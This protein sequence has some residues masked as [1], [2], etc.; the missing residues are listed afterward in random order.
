M[1]P[2]RDWWVCARSQGQP[3]GALEREND[4]AGAGKL[5]GSLLL[6]ICNLLRLKGIS[7]EEALADALENLLKIY[8]IE[9]SP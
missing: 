9:D 4:S 8:E 7:G 5:A 2:R 6:Q 1:Q 3:S